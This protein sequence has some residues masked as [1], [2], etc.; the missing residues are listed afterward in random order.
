[1]RVFCFGGRRWRSD[2]HAAPTIC[3]CRNVCGRL[4]CI[5]RDNGFGCFDLYVEITPTAL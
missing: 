3:H 5:L 4:L 1:M 2:V